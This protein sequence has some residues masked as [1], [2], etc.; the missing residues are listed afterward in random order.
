MQ[1]IVK[2]HRKTKETDITI[3]YGNTEKGTPLVETGVPFFNHLLTSFAFHGNFPL[4]IQAVGDIDV[5][6]HHLVED[7]GIVLG[8]LFSDIMLENKPITR[9]G[10]AVIPMDDALSEAVI[11][12]SGRPHLEYQA[13]FPQQYSGSFDMSL[14]KEFFSAFSANARLNLHLIARN[15]ENSHHIG[16]SLM[17]AFG[18]ALAQSL[19]PI[20]NSNGDLSTKGTLT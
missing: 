11:D 5:D 10:H 17:K 20:S 6:P 8:S 13:E 2:K 16:E 4:D 18:R 9:F 7:V 12:Y 14:L 3:I 19:V 1:G 15:G